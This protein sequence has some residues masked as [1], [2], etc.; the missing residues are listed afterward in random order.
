[1]LISHGC[2]QK[3]LYLISNEAGYIIFSTDCLMSAD[4]CQRISTIL[5][6]KSDASAWN[7]IIKKYVIFEQ[8]GSNPHSKMIERR[9]SVCFWKR[10]C[11]LSCF[12][13]STSDHKRASSP[14]H[15]TY[16]SH[17][18]AIWRPPLPRLKL[19]GIRPASRKP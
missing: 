19:P 16:A 3:I 12:G 7:I 6:A 1:M 11:V 5:R 13:L 2:R 8:I 4:L 14:P 9:C 17:M 18:V 10:V 15:I